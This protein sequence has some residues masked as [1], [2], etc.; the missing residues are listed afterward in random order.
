MPRARRITPPV[1]RRPLSSGREVQGVIYKKYG[2]KLKV[3]AYLHECTAGPD[4]KWHR[5]LSYEPAPLGAGQEQYTTP[6]VECRLHMGRH[7][8]VLSLVVMPFQPEM[9][10]PFVKEKCLC[11]F[12]GLLRDG[13][14]HNQ[15]AI[16]QPLE[17]EC[18][19]L[20]AFV[21]KNMTVAEESTGDFMP[22]SVKELAD[23]AWDHLSTL[24]VK[25]VSGALPF[26]SMCA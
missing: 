23:A 19:Y 3:S 14:H 10:N 17:Q 7:V 5:Y 24:P 4:N 16:V 1:F 9:P 2:G 20:S 26:C 12:L 11:R 21:N 22:L 8:E 15:W 13:E 6:P 25:T 18:A